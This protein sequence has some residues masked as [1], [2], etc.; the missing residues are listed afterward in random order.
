MG[1]AESAARMAASLLAIAQTRLE[2]AATEVEE[3][4][5]RYFSYLLLSLAAMFCIGLAIVL[6]TLLIVVLYWDTNRIG[7]LLVLT[8]LFAFVGIMIGLRVRSRYRD[9]PK[10]LLHTMTE[11]SRDGEMLQPPAS[12]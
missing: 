1:I 3:E 10:L 11:L 8:V 4:S 9:K 7:V 6:G 5:L 2:L 12:T